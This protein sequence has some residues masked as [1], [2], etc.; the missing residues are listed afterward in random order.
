MDFYS[1]YAIE[2]RRVDGGADLGSVG[3]DSSTEGHEVW[4]VVDHRWPKFGDL[5]RDTRLQPVDVPGRRRDSP[6]FV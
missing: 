2:Y 3:E 4:L 1:R 5:D 6:G